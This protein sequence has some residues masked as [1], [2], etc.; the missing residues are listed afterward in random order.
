MAGCFVAV[1][2]FAAEARPNIIV[3]LSDDMGFSDIGCYGGEIATP[4]LDSLAK[5][6]LRFTQF[7]NTA[8]CCPTRASLLTGLYPHQAGVGHM[9][10]DRGVDGYRGRLNQQCVTIA[11]ALRPAGYRTYALGKWHVTPAPGPRSQADKR[12]WPLQRGFDRYYG[13]IP[14]AGSFFDPSGLVRDNNVI[15]VA[16][17]PEY[18]PKDFYYTDALAEHGVRFIREHAR[19]HKGKPFFLYT[20]FTAAHWPLHAKESDVA[21]YKGR[22]DEGYEPIREARWAKA[23]KLGIVDEKWGR[24]P[25][26]E[27]WDE[28]KDKAFD[29]RC[30]EVYAAQVDSMDQGIGRIVA[31]LKAQGL[32]ENTLILYMQDNGGCAEPIGRGANATA[33]AEKPTLSAMKPDEQ[34]FGS[35][36][37]QTRDGWPVRVGY[38]VMPGGPDTFIAYGRGWANVSNT[39]FR[40]YKHWTHEGG[41]ST[42]LIAHWPAGIESS[43]RNRLEKTPAHLIDIMATCVDLAAAK[44]PAEQAGQKIKPLQG[45]TLRP[46]F[47]GRSIKRE[48]PIFWEHEANRAV[49]SGKWKLV[50]KENQP[51]E[52]YDMEKDR[53]ELHD[54]AAQ[55]PQKA[56]ELAAAWEEYARRA[57]VL[58]LGAWRRAEAGS[59]NFSKQTRFALKAGDHL[60]RGEAPNIAG[61]AFSV[62]AKFDTKEARDGVIVAQGGS[63]IGYALFLKDGKVAFIVRSGGNVAQVESRDEIRG[64]HMVVAALDNAGGLSLLIDNQ[65]ITTAK[66]NLIRSMPIDGLEVGSDALGAVGGYTSP[67][68]F[69]GTIESILIEIGPAAAD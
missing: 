35:Q 23:K 40:E 58:P 14:G 39:P 47:S 42:P 48:Q 66:G 68:A 38:G 62:T 18:Q 13:T 30:M 50:A 46:A 10:E 7:Y 37:R 57:D 53:A 43:R 25:A 34:Q 33:R 32:F 9:M 63:N 52:L 27:K 22:Y 45:V 29:A 41:I 64:A 8:R 12:N 15:T 67:N 2:L 20:A 3:I 65:T 56:K 21:K 49:R 17:D 51:W 61:K 1:S 5:N 54:L 26:A 36:P 28:V 16:N 44:Y 4:N 31:E 19:D 55:H 6:G 69:S 24:A 59:T 11:E 60:D